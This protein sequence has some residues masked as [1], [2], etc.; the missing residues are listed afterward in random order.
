MTEQTQ[1]AESYELTRFNALSHGVLSRY[2]VL[3]WED[4]NEYRKLLE[5]LVAE[6]APSGPT[7]E[8]LVEEI[9]GIFWRKRRL[10]LAEAAAHRRQLAK[11]VS[12][13]EDTAE[14][15]VAHLGEADEGEAE[16]VADALRSDVATT[17]AEIADVDED[18]ATTKRALL[19]LDARDK[20]AYRKALGVL[21]EDTRGWW[22]H[23]LAEAAEDRR[24]AEPAYAADAVSL[25]R[26]FEDEALP[27]MVRHRARLASRPLVREQV[28]GEA[29]DTPALERLGR[30]EVHLDR[31]LERMLAMLFR[32][33]ELR[34]PR[35]EEG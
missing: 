3:P 6:H 9:A 35:A 33:K 16:D 13:G 12:G 32:L 15:A 2:V 10:R 34:P 19:L 29:V 22:E 17:A 4:G 20:D 21:G 1:G 30:Y 27:M 23:N 28:F 25:M 26:F 7:E 18:T 11:A 14:A 31:K 8:H 24:G 5:A